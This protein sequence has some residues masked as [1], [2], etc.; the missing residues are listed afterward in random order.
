MKKKILLLAAMV[1]ASSTTI[2]AQRKFPFFWKKKNAKT[3]QTTP[4]KKE[5]EYDKLFKKKHEIAKGLITLHLLDGKVYFE[6]P[7]NLINKDML[8]G[9]TVTSISDN[10]NAVVGSKPTD[11]LHVVFTRN[12]THVQ[13]R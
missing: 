7:V 1:V 9:S 5:S 2:D 10:G 4:A 12:K 8:I 11:L 13:L 6:L 3:E